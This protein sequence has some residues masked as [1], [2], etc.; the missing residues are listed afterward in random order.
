MMINQTADVV[1][2]QSPVFRGGKL[3]N[4]SHEEV[5]EVAYRLWLD[6]GS[7]YG[8]ADTDWFEAKKLLGLSN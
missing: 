4:P 7:R 8:D 2:S 5:A 1:I 6:R 3:W